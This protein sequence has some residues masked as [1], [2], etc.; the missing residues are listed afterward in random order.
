MKEALKFIDITSIFKDKKFGDLKR[1]SAK[2]SIGGAIVIYALNT[3]GES[4]SWEG[5]VL[6]TIGILP[7]CLS[8]FENRKCGNK[9]N[10]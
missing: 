2:R 8:M 9:C 6:C 7:L 3:M 5:V 1:W 10:C 4:I